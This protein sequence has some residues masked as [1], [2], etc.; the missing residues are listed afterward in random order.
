LRVANGALEQAVRIKDEFLATMSHELRTPLNTI[1]GMAEALQ[2]E[3]YG[4][5]NAKQQDSLRH[6]DESGR[7]LL[8]LI[9]DILDLS[10]AQA[11]KFEL[12]VEALACVHDARPALILMDIQMPGMDGLEAIRRIRADSTIAAIPII[13][14]TALAMTSDRERCLAAGADDYITKPVSLRGL[15]TTIEACLRPPTAAVEP[16]VEKQ[17]FI[18]SQNR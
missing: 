5:M 6:I 1:L 4:A 9:N 17:E 3:M 10:K 8:T 11:G 16:S 18:V 12:D 13:A 2:E 7:H 14:L 15:V